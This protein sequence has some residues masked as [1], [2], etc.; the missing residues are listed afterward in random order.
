MGWWRFRR[1]AGIPPEPTPSSSYSRSEPRRRRG[2]HARSR[3][4]TGIPLDSTRGRCGSGDQSR[5]CQQPC[6]PRCPSSSASQRQ[7]PPTDPVAPSLASNSRAS[8]ILASNC[9]SFVMARVPP[10][11]VHG[12]IPPASLTR[13]NEAVDV[14]RLTATSKFSSSGSPHLR[15]SRIEFGRYS[16]SPANNKCCARPSLRSDS[17][18]A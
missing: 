12:P 2:M 6:P 4:S 1:I 7:Q 3:C 18:Y 16:G 10:F 14:N 8:N 11:G 15:L 17:R 13:V 5:R 9:V